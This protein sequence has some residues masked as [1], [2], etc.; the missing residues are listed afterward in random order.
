MT[1]L[2]LALKEIGYRK[3][4]F[5]LAI[6]AVAVAAACLVGEL[7]LLG[8]HEARSA[9]LDAAGEAATRSRAGKLEDDTTKIMLGLGY[10]VLVL[11][12]D[13]DLGAFYARG[14]AA[15]TLPEEYV[16]RLA[17]SKIITVQHLLPTLQRKIEWPERK[18][19]IVLIGTRGEAPLAHRDP[20][21]PLR[22]AVAKGSMVI[23]QV[24]H[25][26]LGLAAG[27]AAALMGRTFTV[28]KVH[29]R[30]GNEDD[31]TV[32]IPLDDAQAL[33]GE[34]GRI[35]AIL[36]LS[37]FC[38]EATSD[39]IRKEIAGIL[40]GN[41]Q[42]VELAPQAATRRAARARAA[43]NRTESVTAEAAERAE[44]RRER[45]ALAAWV[46][47]LVIVGCTVWVGL[48]AFGNARDRRSEIGILRALGVRAGQVMAVFLIRAL[49]VGLAGAAVGFAVGWAVAAV[50]DA[51]ESGADAAGAAALFNGGLLAATLVAAP[52][53]SALAAFVPAAL[54]TRQDPAAVLRDN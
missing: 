16:R 30:R 47:P 6:V 19:P 5:A 28:E 54:A 33:L 18:F 20:K 26:R 52:I 1:V 14:Y 15:R 43:E 31:V 25:E 24:V 44:R 38:A 48:L 9:T 29:P 4:S 22:P 12:K 11:A 27:D 42:T 50:W 49:A 41:V 53:L 10:N 51:R 23:G 45:E 13:E 40:D 2:Q 35:N 32:W 7:T 39:G 17:D 3:A 37:C 34:A 36:A 8:A 21:K 46:V